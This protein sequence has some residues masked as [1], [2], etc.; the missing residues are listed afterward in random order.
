MNPPTF[1]RRKVDNVPPIITYKWSAAVVDEG[2]IPFP[3]RLLRCLSH[4]L[5]DLRDLQVILAIVDYSRPNLSRPPSYD[6]LAFNAGMTVPEFKQR[7]QHLVQRGWLTVS[8]SDEAVRITMEN[9]I[10]EIERLTEDQ[11]AELEGTP[12]PF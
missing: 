6:Y 7:V 12:H 11:M 5:I 8:G 10:R 9:L 2:Y 3:K 4:L 1:E